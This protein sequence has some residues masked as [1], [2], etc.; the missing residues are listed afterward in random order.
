VTLLAGRTPPALAEGEEPPLV[1]PPARSIRESIAEVRAS[2]DLLQQMVRRDLTTKHAG[3]FLGFFW[4]L[5][6]PMLMVS[7]YATVFYVMGFARTGGEFEDVPFAL[8][9][10][11][12]LVV[13]N[14][15]NVGVAGGTAAVVG[16]GYL[17]RKIYFPRE[18]LPLSVVL[19]GLVTFCFEFV[20]LVVFQTV[21]GH[22][23]QWTI[24]LAIPIIAIVTVLAA[25][26]ALL[27][28]A[29]TVYFRDLQHFIVVALQLLFWG[30]P[31]IYDISLITDKHPAAADVLLLN[32]LTP[33]LIAFRE[34][35][36]VGEVPG[37]WRLLYSAA[38]AVAT[39]VLGWRY[40]N[41]HERRMA[42]LV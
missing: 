32:P 18:L 25:G 26:V 7:V 38:I 4:S 34:C 29:A 40:F 10:F 11:G 2:R 23:P 9:F 1:E 17:V 15:F 28:S 14:V 6:T 16:Q 12:G 36:L 20:V 8:F 42:E 33:C 3:S 30:A 13:W 37:P 27:L 39:L 5:L 24:V 19:A 31:V 21:L 22:H 35:V 41:R